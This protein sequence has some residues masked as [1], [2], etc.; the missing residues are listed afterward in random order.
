MKGQIPFAGKELV[1][2]Q[3]DGFG[4]AGDR[5]VEGAR[6]GLYPDAKPAAALLTR[7]AM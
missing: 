5:Q 2:G 7:P 4:G 6:V 1:Q 3:L